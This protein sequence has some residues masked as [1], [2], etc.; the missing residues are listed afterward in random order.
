MLIMKNLC[1]MIL[2]YLSILSLNAQQLVQIN[3][4][5]KVNFKIKNFG[6]NVT[7]SFSEVDIISYFD[8]SNLDNS[9]INT[10]IKVVSINTG[11]V[12]R[13]EHLFKD[14]FFDVDNY[15]YIK[16][17]S[18]KIEKI[19]GTGYKL[20]AKLSIKNTTKLISIPL[21]IIENNDSLMLKSN[22][23]INRKDY[24]VGGN[25]WVLS[26]NV[27]IEVAYKAKK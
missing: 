6:V 8:H 22:F 23:E 25:T 13:D 11:N 9:Y 19:S 27:K 2:F 12:K 5:T 10:I 18:T 16:L 4:D 21:E 26:N 7:G 20:T 15:K 3:G 24:D 17:E 14:D 1:Y